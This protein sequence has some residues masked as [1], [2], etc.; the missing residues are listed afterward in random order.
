MG[1][2]GDAVGGIFG[3]GDDAADASRE[4]SEASV[5]AQREALE[6]LKER[7]EIPQE[8]REKAIQQYAALLGLPGGQGDSAE[9][10]EGLKQTP[11][12]EAIMGTQ[13]AGEESI[14][15][16]AGATGGLRSGNVQAALADQATQLQQQALLQSYGQQLG[17]LKSLMGQPSMAGDIATGMAGLGAT[18]ASGIIGAAQTQA[19]AQQQGIGNV[20]S[21]VGLGMQLFSDRRLKDNIEFIAEKDGHKWY[22]FNWNEKAEHFGLE[23]HDTGV[24]AQEVQEYYPE[25]INEKDGYLMVDYSKLGEYKNV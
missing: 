21:L 9:I 23:G 20:G 12:Y 24:I 17:G 13:A 2:I 6:Y 10:I 18:E 3:G 25:A 19:A 22:S 7:E 15:R 8:F 4:A 5:A 16:Q 1:F 14:L 11:L